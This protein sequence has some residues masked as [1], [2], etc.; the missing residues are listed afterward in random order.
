M[1]EACENCIHCKEL[2]KPPSFGQKAMYGL[3]CTLFIHEDMV[4]YLDNG[5]SLCECF[6]AKEGGLNG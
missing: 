1:N 5:K 2:Y 6:K 4:M 3:C